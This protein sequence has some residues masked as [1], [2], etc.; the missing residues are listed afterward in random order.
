MKRQDMW[1]D[2]RHST[3][4]LKSRINNWS[5]CVLLLFVFIT[6]PRISTLDL[7]DG[8]IPSPDIG[9]TVWEYQTRVIT[10]Y[11]C[12]NTFMLSSTSRTTRCYLSQVLSV[13]CHMFI[14]LPRWHCYSELTGLCGHVSYVGLIHPFLTVSRRTEIFTWKCLKFLEFVLANLV[15][16]TNWGGR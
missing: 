13:C 3:T 10:N 5:V 14:T 7:N 4:Q 12:H 6:M 11:Y 2:I 16:V 9:Q 15:S 8:L 1:R